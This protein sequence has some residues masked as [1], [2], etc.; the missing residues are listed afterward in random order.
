MIKQKITEIQPIGLSILKRERLSGLPD[1]SLAYQLG[2]VSANRLFFWYPSPLLPDP[3][4]NF[5]ERQNIRMVNCK[6][7]K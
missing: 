3:H 4:E 6:P 1:A 7:N 5:T 2:L